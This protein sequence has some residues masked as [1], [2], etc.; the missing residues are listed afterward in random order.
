MKQIGLFILACIAAV[1][2]YAQRASYNIIPLPKEVKADTTQ[3]FTLKGGMG[4]T[5]DEGNA[6]NT[7]IAHPAGMGDAGYWR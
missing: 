2:V 5:F 6:E 3:F 7:R 4:I 1:S